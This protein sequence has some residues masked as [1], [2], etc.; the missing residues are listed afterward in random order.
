MFSLGVIMHNLLTGRD[1]FVYGAG[2]KRSSSS[3]EVIRQDELKDGDSDSK[4]ASCLE[5][6]ASLLENDPKKRKGE[7]GQAVEAGAAGQQAKKGA[8]SPAS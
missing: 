6:L 5:L 4:G 3:A 8:P 1:P 2:G 7:E